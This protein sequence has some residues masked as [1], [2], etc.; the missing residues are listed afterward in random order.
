MPHRQRNW[1]EHVVHCFQRAPCAACS[2]EWF[3]STPVARAWCLKLVN[4]RLRRRGWCRRIRG[5]NVNQRRRGKEC[6]WVGR[7]KRQRY[8]CCFWNSIHVSLSWL[9]AGYHRRLS[10]C[11][12]Q[13]KLRW[14]TQKLWLSE[15]QLSCTLSACHSPAPP[16][17]IRN[18]WR[19]SPADQL[20]SWPADQ[21]TKGQVTEWQVMHFQLCIWITS[22][23]FEITNARI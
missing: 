2:P 22:R 23:Y 16:L 20:T 11:R 13:Q 7:S 5:G 8:C 9:T 21:L 14:A 12:F 17:T 1:T 4:W 6:V 19:S 15:D 10:C 3:V 18:S